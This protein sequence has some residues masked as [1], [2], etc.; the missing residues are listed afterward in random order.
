MQ[1]GHSSHGVA[2][3]RNGIVTVLRGA[4]LLALTTSVSCG[5]PKERPRED[6]WAWCRRPGIGRAVLCRT[7]DVP[8]T[9]A[10]PGPTVP[11]SMVKV[12]AESDDRRPDPVVLLA[13]GPGQSAIGAYG[14]MLP[15]FNDINRDRDILLIDVRGTSAGHALYCVPDAENDAAE[16]DQLFRT[17]GIA[18][19]AELCNQRLDR[20]TKASL[21]D[22]TT[23]QFVLDLEVVRETLGITRW[24]LIGASYG[25][26]LAMQ[27]AKAY[28][29][30]TRSLVLDAVA[31]RQLRLPL[32]FAR[33]MESALEVVAAR[34]R[35]DAP[36]LE[37]NGDP[38]AALKAFFS[39]LPKKMVV[40]HPRTGLRHEVEVTREA[41]AQLIRGPLYA[42]DLQGLLPYAIR[43]AREG[44]LSPL[45]GI[46]ALM[47]QGSELSLGV[48]LSVT[49]A[50]DIPRIGP[51][52]IGPATEG[53]VLGDTVVRDFIAACERWDGTTY[54]PKQEPLPPSI[55]VLTLSG[56]VDPVTP[57]RWA[58][59][60]ME[61]VQHH[62]RVVMAHAGHGI[63]ARGCV[64][65]LVGEFLETPRDAVDARCVE[66]SKPPPFF[67]DH[68]GAAP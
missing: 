6:G 37:H 64:P 22:V 25:T 60:A 54:T 34:C 18:H 58:D 42:T 44:D 61:G 62:H 32:P 13:G 8:A 7:V 20:E 68:A 56:T 14:P 30:A 35:E 28:P 55:P 59:V 27:Y 17:S 38:L 66:R 2:V 40:T 50:E 63:L 57:V 5:K 48:L 3:V 31:P 47:D 53:T 16:L 51:E 41:V 9:E 29:D 11:I 36:C 49:C 19:G 43:R 45:L 46:A 4:L 52:E 24:N 15:V 65:R 26:R 33:D 67:I 39:T 1:A 10:Q 12:P 21:K 23:R